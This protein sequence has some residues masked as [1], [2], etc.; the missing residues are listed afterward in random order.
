VAGALGLAA[1]PPLPAAVPSEE[2]VK[3]AF[4]YHF[5]Q[6]VEWPAEAKGAG[7]DFL[8]AILDADPFSEVVARMLAGKR[9]AGR[10]LLVRRISDPSEGAAARV[11]FVGATEPKRLVAV[12][13]ALQGSRVLTVGD[14]QGFAERGG[15]IGFR[16]VDRHVRFDVNLEQTGRSGFRI[17]SQ[18]LKLARVVRTRE[19]P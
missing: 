8:V 11:V 10:P 5:T 7:D 4:L 3:A 12:L 17:S 18:V 19:T 9:A 1:S 14:A 13:Q 16:T 15:M 2:E 6:F